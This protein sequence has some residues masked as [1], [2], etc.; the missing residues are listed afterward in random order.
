MQ[1][2]RDFTLKG[3]GINPLGK[4]RPAQGRREQRPQ[5]FEDPYAGDG[6]R[7]SSAGL[8][9]KPHA[10]QAFPGENIIVLSEEEAD[11]LASD[12]KRADLKAFFEKQSAD[13][14]AATEARRVA[15]HQAIDA[16]L[17]A[18]KK[19]AEARLAAQI[20]AINTEIANTKRTIDL[21]QNESKR[22]KVNEASGDGGRPF[23]KQEAQGGRAVEQEP[24]GARLFIKQEPR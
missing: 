11:R 5:D 19:A 16:R 10:S 12:K 4:P 9:Q 18:D 20:K 2:G 15:E 1:D 21:L 7:Q 14:N 24:Q 13:E 23:I 8:M 6:R 22:S 17:A 3:S